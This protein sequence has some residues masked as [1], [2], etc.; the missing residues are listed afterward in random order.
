MW[1]A[2][3]DDAFGALRLLVLIGFFTGAT[4]LF[5]VGVKLLRNMG[6]SYFDSD[7]RHVIAVDLKTNK[8]KTVKV[9]TQS[10]IRR[11][12]E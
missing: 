11:M 3:W 12:L 2:V 4:L 1:D 7:Y 5:I 8:W 10:F 9:P 6:R